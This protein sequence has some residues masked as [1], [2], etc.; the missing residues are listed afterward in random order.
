ML[1][2]N[3]DKHFKPT[4]IPISRSRFDE[5]YPNTELIIMMNSLQYTEYEKT[6][7]IDYMSICCIEHLMMMPN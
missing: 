5:L 4:Q 2:N 6:K 7:K 3:D 1:I